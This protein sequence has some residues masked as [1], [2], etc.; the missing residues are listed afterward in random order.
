M[1]IGGK[2]TFKWYL[3]SEQTHTQIHIWPNR[4]IESIDPEG[5]CFKTKIMQPLNVF[6]EKNHATSK[7]NFSKIVLVLL[8]ASVEKVCVSRMRDFFSINNDIDVYLINQSGNK[9]DCPGM[10]RSR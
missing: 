4:P 2:K 3:K 5:P 7:K 1:E 9:L 8:S 6:F 10:Y